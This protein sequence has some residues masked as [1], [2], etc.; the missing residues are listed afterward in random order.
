MPDPL[1]TIAFRQDINLLDVAWMGLFTPDVVESYARQVRARFV[2]EA[3]RPGY[4]LRMDMSRSAV[5]PQDAVAAFRDHLGDF[6][7]ARRIAV[8]TASAIAKLQ[9]RREMRQPY[10]RLFDAAGP[11]LDWLLEPDMALA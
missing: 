4:L 1:Y 8:V 2:S 9:V 11:A 5:Q 3:F 7:R 6:P 10:L